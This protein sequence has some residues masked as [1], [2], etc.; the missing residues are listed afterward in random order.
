MTAQ[1]NAPGS[2]HDARVAR[3]IYEKLRDHTPAGY[4][5]VCDTAFLR[6]SVVV[7]GHI[8]APLKDGQAAPTDADLQRK[9]LAFN[10]ALLSYRQTAEWGMRQVQGAF[11][12]LRVPL[13]IHDS[14]SRIHI[15][16]MVMRLN[17][18]RVRCVGISQIRNVYMPI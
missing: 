11:E 6:G 15:L 17:N 13:K 12:R 1:L 8:K 18:L 14:D 9:V 16:E 4:Y 10:R 7:A 5:L 2:W 3:P